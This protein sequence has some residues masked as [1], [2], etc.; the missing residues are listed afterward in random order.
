MGLLAS[1]SMGLITFFLCHLESDAA[2]YFDVAQF[3]CLILKAQSQ[4]LLWA[5]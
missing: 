3:Q 2:H 5:Y 4:F 1:C